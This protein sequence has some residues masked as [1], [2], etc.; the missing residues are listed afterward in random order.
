MI[1]KKKKKKE[2]EKKKHSDI[3][4]CP[5]NDAYFHYTFGSSKETFKVNK[6]CVGHWNVS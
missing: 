5:T 6:I 3:F 4:K 1:K 2:T